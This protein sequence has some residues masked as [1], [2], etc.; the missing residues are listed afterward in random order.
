[1]FEVIA[2]VVQ[3]VFV[4]LMRQVIKQSTCMM[5]CCRGSECECDLRQLVRQRTSKKMQYECSEES[6]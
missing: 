5:K 4:F 2:V 6:T 3:G 1:M